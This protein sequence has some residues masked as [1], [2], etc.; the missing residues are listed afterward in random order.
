MSTTSAAVVAGHP[1]VV[2]GQ[3]V[4]AV[5]D[6]LGEVPVWSLSRAE[7]RSVLVSLARVEARVAGLRLRVL[8][9]ADAA[10]VGAGSGASSTAAWV[11][12]QTRQVR[13]GAGG[14]HADLVLARELDS[15]L[16]ATGV[17][18]AAGRVNIEQA[19]VIARA[20][21]GLPGVGD[22]G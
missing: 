6:S 16:T 13:G 2:F 22:G 17:A 7:Q 18:L 20:V 21:A 4:H 10:D 12:Q 15:S 11:A 8:A 5:L 1:V 14:A 9:A 19:R 3:R